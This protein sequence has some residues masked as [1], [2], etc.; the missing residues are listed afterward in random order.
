[1][2]VRIFKTVIR[3]TTEIIKNALALLK[4]KLPAIEFNHI[5]RLL[6]DGANRDLI[7]LRGIATGVQFANL[8]KKKADELI[9]VL[10][11]G[12]ERENNGMKIV[13]EKDDLQKIDEILKGSFNLNARRRILITIS[14]AD[15]ILLN[16]LIATLEKIYEKSK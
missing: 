5:K 11:K 6:Y 7:F 8:P 4:D 12:I 10:K 15:A 2:P 14:R 16:S 3:S 1:M 9:K 13:F